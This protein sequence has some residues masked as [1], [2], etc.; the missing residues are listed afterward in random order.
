M[1]ESKQEVQLRINLTQESIVE[2]IKEKD[3]AQE[4]ANI[5]VCWKNK[6]SLERKC[7]KM[8]LDCYEMV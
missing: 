3:M 7:E 2:L 8:S 5:E 1:R 4:E 6:L